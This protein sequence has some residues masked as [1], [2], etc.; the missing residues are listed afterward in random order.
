MDTRFILT[1][2]IQRMVLFFL[3]EH[4]ELSPFH[5]REARYDFS[6]EYPNSSITNLALWGHYYV[7]CG[8]PGRNHTIRWS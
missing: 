8:L 5:L 7:K 2:D 6:L 4:Q 1:V 3:P